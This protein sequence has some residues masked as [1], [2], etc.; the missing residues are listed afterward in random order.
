[1]NS[2]KSSIFLSELEN[3]VKD[4]LIK[5]RGE[6]EARVE[7][8]INLNDDEKNK[9]DKLLEKVLK[10][11]IKT[12]FNIKP[13]L[14]GGF[15]IRVGDWRLDATLIHQLNVMKKTLGGS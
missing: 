14:L 8:A 3:S 12:L 9:I 10:R 5:T 2:E 15:R 6:K 4:A 1:M 7:S 11:R 13:G